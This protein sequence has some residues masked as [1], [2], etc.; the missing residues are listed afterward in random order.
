MKNNFKPNGLQYGVYTFLVNEDHTQACM[1]FNPTDEKYSADLIDSSF[2]REVEFLSYLQS[3]NVEWIPDGLFID[4]ES[5][6]IYFNWYGNTCED[7]L[8]PD[9]KNQLEHIIVELD[10]FKIY[11][12]SFYPKCF[13]TDSNN[14][15]R[16]YSFYTACTHNASIVD[17]AFYKPILNPDRLAI[18]ES[19]AVNGKL[20]IR[21]LIEQAFL[22]Y[23][24]WP[25][26]TLRTIYLKL[27]KSKSE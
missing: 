8:P 12:P 20:D 25:D 26:D 10:K 22:N 4:R 18:V 2:N 23:I 27:L 3:S 16:T 15:I 6:K 14:K 17:V 5:R 19:L 24:K 7:R 21:L 1:D 11:K 13:Y 9:W